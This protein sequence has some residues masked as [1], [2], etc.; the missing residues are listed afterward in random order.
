MIK[1]IAEANMDIM[2][3][4]IHEIP[5]YRFRSLKEP[6]KKR[7]EALEESLRFH[8]FGFELD[9]ELQWI[10]DHLPQASSTTLGQNLHQAQTLHKK[11]K[12]LEAEIAG[13]QPMIDK[14]LTSGQAL[15][16]QIHPEK[17]KVNCEQFCVS[18][19]NNFFSLVDSHDDWT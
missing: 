18:N 9:A 7:R 14:T 11:H 17:K 2:I 19:I 10:K 6:A 12:K 16:D 1:F 4:R 8:K 3:Q 5:I 15:I 13:H